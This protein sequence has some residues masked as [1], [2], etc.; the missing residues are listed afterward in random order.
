MGGIM[1]MV[2]NNIA[3]VASSPSYNTT[4]LQLYYDPGNSASYSGSGSVITDL[5][6]NNR[7]GVVSGSPTDAGNWFTL[8]GSTQ[9]FYSPVLS[10]GA[11]NSCTVEVWVR[12]T[13]DC[14]VWTDQD[15]QTPNSSYFATGCE[16]YPTGPF[17]LMNT[18]LYNSGTGVTRCGGGV[19][20]LNT[21]YQIVRTYDGT[22]AVGYQNAVAASPTAISWSAPT[23]WYVGFGA[24]ATTKFAQGNAFAG[25]YGLVRVYNRALTGAE[26]LQNYNADKATYGL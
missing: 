12:A 19:E 22:N 1:Q 25:S 4:G 8:N 11:G 23:N 21:W 15:S 14:A 18:M 10:R 3:V 5:S 16:I 6:G 13:A 17:H 2:T 7:T 24:P 26:V 20:S 9:W